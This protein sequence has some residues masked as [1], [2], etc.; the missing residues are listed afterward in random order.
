MIKF[1]NVSTKTYI[2]L[3]S[4]TSIKCLI[5]GLIS[6]YL[7]DVKNKYCGH[8]HQFHEFLTLPNRSR[9]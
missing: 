7:E 6:Y 3:H 8:C 4:G 9:L 1:K 2:I 5:C